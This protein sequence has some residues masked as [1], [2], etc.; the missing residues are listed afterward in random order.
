EYFQGAAL[1]VIF[2]NMATAVLGRIGTD[3]RPLWNPRLLEFARYY[4]FTPVACAVRDPDRK[5][6]KE[7][8]FRYFEDDFIKGSAFGTWEELERR[9]HAWLDHTPGVGNCR[10]HGTTGV[11]PNEVWL[12]ERDLLIALPERR[13]TVGREVFRMVDTDCTVAVGGCRYSVPA[14]LAG[15]QIQVRLCAEHF[16]VR[17]PMGTLIYSRKYVD[18]STH[19]GSLVIDPTHYA[20]LPRR[21]RDQVDSG[22]L[23]RDFLNRFPTLAVLVDGLKIRMKTIA[24]I[25]LRK[26]L[27]LADA[28]GV[29]VFLE[30]ATKAQIHRRFDANAVGR[31][32]EREYPPPPVE[33]VAPIN[34]SGPAILGE[35]EES[36]LDDFAWL[37]ETLE[38]EEEDNDGSK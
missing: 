1:R 31:I 10:K 5:G 2:D 16:E 27:R 20:N 6:K 30:A 17:N 34:G 36:T 28:Y 8:S 29:E 7:K 3:R 23:D 26:L 15:H 19:P 25:H 24:P 35:V 21:P 13:F 4:G 12:A 33:I 18:R 38:N 9:L 32:L 37:D 11:I 14:V 22:R